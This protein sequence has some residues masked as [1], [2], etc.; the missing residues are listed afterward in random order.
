MYFEYP[1][2]LFLLLIPVLLVGRYL[3]IELKDRR[4][5]MRVSALEA[6]KAGG[7]SVFE[8]L[9]LKRA[10][11]SAGTSDT[12]IMATPWGNMAFNL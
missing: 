4:A 6:W 2:L 1:K 9:A 5:H 3:Y 12:E 11:R 10:C 8:V 7:R